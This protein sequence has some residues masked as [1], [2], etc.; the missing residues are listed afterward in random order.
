MG[1]GTALLVCTGDVQLKRYQGGRRQRLCGAPSGPA[2]ARRRRGLAWSTCKNLDVIGR[3]AGAG[4]G[5]P[6][7]QGH[8]RGDGGRHGG[9]DGQ[10]NVAGAG[11]VY[12]TP[13]KPAPTQILVFLSLLGYPDAQ[14]LEEDDRRLPDDRRHSARYTRTRRTSTPSVRPEEDRRPAWWGLRREVAA[15]AGRGGEAARQGAA[16]DEEHQNGSRSAQ[17]R[18]R[19]SSTW[20]LW[21]SHRPAS[22]S[23]RAPSRCAKPTRSASSSCEEPRTGGGPA[24]TPRCACATYRR[25]MTSSAASWTWPGGWR[26]T[27][28]TSS[29]SATTSLTRTGTVAG[30]SA[31]RRRYGTL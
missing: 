17:R 4:V 2:W 21:R 14:A 30:I 23:W 26:R 31:P 6:R 10:E 25:I 8:G 27:R 3:P 29:S 24:T 5:T 13:D 7:G 20:T 15:G 12:S 11:H 28:R 22:T 1:S 16:T 19:T 18:S 9:V